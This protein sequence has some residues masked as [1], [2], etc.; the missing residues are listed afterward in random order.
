MSSSS[1]LLSKDSFS[2]Q[3]QEYPLLL[4]G[5]GGVPLGSIAT[6]GRGPGVDVNL[7]L[8]SGE[9]V[10][11]LDGVATSGGGFLGVDLNVSCRD[12]KLRRW[13]DYGDNFLEKLW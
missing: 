12:M 9:G 6:S 8:L 13:F 3:V 2:A 11:P 10:T 4:S 5:R 7:E 1:S